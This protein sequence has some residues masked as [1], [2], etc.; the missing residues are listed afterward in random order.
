MCSLMLFSSGWAGLFKRGVPKSRATNNW[1]IRSHSF[2]R[3]LADEF[4]EHGARVLLAPVRV[5]EPK[6]VGVRHDAK[7]GVI[8]ERGGFGIV[9][10]E[11]RVAL[12][13]GGGRDTRHDRGAF[14]TR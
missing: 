7:L 11:R 4:G 3:L 12:V 9:V 1:E 10:K 5:A 13:T 6:V 8:E 14:L 2:R